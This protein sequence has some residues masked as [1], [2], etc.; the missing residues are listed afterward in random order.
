MIF[1]F[2]RVPTN[3]IKP[4]KISEF[5]IKLHK[6]CLIKVTNGKVAEFSYY[7]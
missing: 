2:V 5:E 6:N 7:M 3:F 1:Y 4:C